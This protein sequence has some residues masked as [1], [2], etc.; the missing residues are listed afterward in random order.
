MIEP[1]FHWK[2]AKQFSWLQVF[3]AFAIPSAVGFFGFHYVLP[4]LHEG[5]MPAIVAWPLV[6]S[7][8]LLPLTIVPVL[9]MKR[10]ATDLNISLKARM[11][12]KS[13]SGKEWLIALGILIIGLIAAAGLGSL[14]A[15]WSEFSGLKVPEYFPFF[16]NP[17]IDPMTADP[18][19]LT[20]GFVLKGAFWLVGL[21]LIT[22][23]LNILVEELYFRAWLLP[24]MQ[25]LSVTPWLVNGLAFAF[26]HIFQLWLLPQILPLSLLMAFV[27][28]KTKS[29]WP[30][31]II[32][33]LTNSLTGVA[34]FMLI[35]G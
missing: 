17:A 30:V 20:P 12:L 29:I 33:L 1:E 13:L 3:L 11:C 34:M 9:M 5:G 7:I 19:A 4:E 15:V 14:S 6:A 18:A 35:M 10:E 16:L 21:M 2:D 25:N 8:M 22:L 27:V 23:F 31:F 28:Y 32:H 26:Y 24:K